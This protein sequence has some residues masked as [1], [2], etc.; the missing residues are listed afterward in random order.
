MD[1][2][3]AKALKSDLEASVALAEVIHKATV[4]SQAK[5]LGIPASG[6][7]GLTPDEI[8]FHPHV[9]AAKRSYDRDFIQLRKFNAAFLK[10]YKADLAAERKAQK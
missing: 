2:A 7:T 3:Q 8:K 4:Q 10:A 6:P 9:R 5:R 1:F